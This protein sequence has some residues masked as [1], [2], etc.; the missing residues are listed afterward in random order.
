MSLWHWTLFQGVATEEGWKTVTT[1]MRKLLQV[2]QH[3]IKIWCVCISETC[4]WNL[5]WK[6]IFVFFIF[7]VSLIFVILP[8]NVIRKWHLL[9]LKTQG[10]FSIFYPYS[11][12]YFHNQQLIIF[13]VSNDIFFLLFCTFN[14]KFKCR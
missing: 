2:N 8:Y 13:T 6:S 9:V 10:V 5:M 3:I 7:K 1:K 12:H 14:L 4:Y 11:F